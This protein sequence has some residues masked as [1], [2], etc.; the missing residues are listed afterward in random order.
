MKIKYYLLLLFYTFCTTLYKIDLGSVQDKVPKYY[1]G[2][3]DYNSDIS[4]IQIS[5]ISKSQ[6]RQY[7]K[8][9]I[10][11]FIKEIHYNLQGKEYN[12]PSLQNSF[13][14]LLDGLFEQIQKK[15]KNIKIQ[16]DNI[17]PSTHSIHIWVEEDLNTPHTFSIKMR[18]QRITDPEIYFDFSISPIQ[19]IQSGQEKRVDMLLNR[20]NIQF[21]E[22]QTKFFLKISNES[23]D[24]FLE[25]FN[26]IGKG[27]VTITSTTKNQIQIF[28]DQN[29]EI[30]NGE[31]P[32][33]LTLLEG[34]YILYAKKRGLE[35]KKISFNITE[36]NEEIIPLKWKDEVSISYINFFSNDSIRFALDNEL[37]G[38]NPV[39]T[40]E[41]PKGFYKIELSQKKNE[42]YEVLYKGDLALKDHHYVNLFYPISFKENFTK[43]SFIENSKK[44]F[45]FF[46]KKDPFLKDEYFE[47]NVF[48]LPYEKQL[49]TPNIILDDIKGEFNF[50]CEDCELVFYFE[51]DHK[52][53]LRKQQDLVYIYSGTDPLE[54]KNIYKLNLKD[55]KNLF[56]YWDYS[57]NDQ[58]FSIYLNSELIVSEKIPS[59]YSVIEFRS[60]KKIIFKDFYVAE[61]QRESF[62]FKK[63]YF[64]KKSFD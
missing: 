31:S 10:V 36:N 57:T 17:L 2:N 18:I 16:K 22:L 35:P 58:Y 6:N 55:N 56:F 28:N 51:K 13:E 24:N 15:Y 21:N 44:N 39:Y 62:L 63:L 60:I 50:F 61:K 11:L 32:V 34:N 40:P 48:F 53:F 41:L 30:Y 25:N 5:E 27:K 54:L 64:F 19:L 37:K 4:L 20:N 52:I 45:W 29:I 38:I 3:F 26:R 14:I 33:L 43:E 1:L 8:E 59:I 7:L 23:I 49:F 46:N 42:E 47:N 9:N 12:I